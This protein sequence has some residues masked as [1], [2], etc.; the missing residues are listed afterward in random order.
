MKDRVEVWY[1]DTKYPVNLSVNTDEKIS[2]L[3][4]GQ[5]E[6]LD[7]LFRNLEASIKLPQIDFP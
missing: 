5:L 7:Q 3:P 2:D 4:A 6:E 1:V